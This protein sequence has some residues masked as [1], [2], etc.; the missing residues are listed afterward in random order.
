VG[1]RSVGVSKRD[2]QDLP[3]V[4][5]GI[6]IEKVVKHIVVDELYPLDRRNHYEILRNAFRN[7]I[8]S[9]DQMIPMSFRLTSAPLTFWLGNGEED[10]SQFDVATDWTGCL[11]D[12]ILIRVIIV[13]AQEI[14]SLPLHRRQ[15]LHAKFLPTSTKGTAIAVVLGGMATAALMRLLILSPIVLEIRRELSDEA[16]KK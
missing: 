7:E 5:L 1:G 10:R 2:R 15:P 14:H 11:C 13:T 9:L 16:R 3:F 6:K 4:F 12:P 8:M